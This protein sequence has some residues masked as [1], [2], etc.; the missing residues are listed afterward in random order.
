MHICF[1]IFILYIE[2]LIYID[3]V[4]TVELELRMETEVCE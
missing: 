3:V 2:C 1:S 4:F